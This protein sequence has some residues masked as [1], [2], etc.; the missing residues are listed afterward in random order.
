MTVDKIISDAKL[1]VVRGWLLKHGYTGLV[2]PK[3]GC[4]CGLDYVAPC[5]QDH[6]GECEPGYVKRCQDCKKKGT[7][8]CKF[9]GSVYCVSLEK[10]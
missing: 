8:D 1:D 7:D 10:E 4:G 9:P 5:G 2:C 3:D 6:M